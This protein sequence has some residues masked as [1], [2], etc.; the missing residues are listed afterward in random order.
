[1]TDTDAASLSG[2]GVGFRQ[3]HYDALRASRPPLGFLE[4]HSENYFGDGGGPLHVLEALRADHDISLHGVG[5]SLGS[6]CGLDAR[7]LEQLR[8]L[9]ERVD[10]IR[11][12]DHVCFGRAMGPGGRPVHG[13]DLLP[14]AFTSASLDIL[15][16][17]VQ[18]TQDVLKRPILVENLSAY[19][20]WADDHI[21][22]VDFLIALCQR[23]GCQLLLDLNNLLVNGLN[24]ARRAR[25][26]GQPFDQPDVDL[27]LADT[28]AFVQ[29]LPRELIGQ[30]H[31]AGFR[32]PARDDLLVIDDHSQ[33]VSAAAWAAYDASLKAW[34]D[35]PTLIEWDTD[36]P[37]FAVLLGEARLAAQHQHGYAQAKAQ[38]KEPIA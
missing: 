26:A 18:Q 34:G 22:E 32:W 31:L 27:A 17:Q 8:R 33:R 20:S 24:R 38:P 11:V 21:P 19:L 25:W 12:S 7:H 1:M 5:L 2:I 16:S 28:L 10:P 14:V 37:D 29:A 13:S 9:S 23:S 35:V 30:I 4:V 15:V 36:L 6:A 3:P